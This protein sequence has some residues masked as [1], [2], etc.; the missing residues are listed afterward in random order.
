MDA[1]EAEQQ[2]CD[3]GAGGVGVAGAFRHKRMVPRL[4]LC[5][6]P[7]VLQIQ[8]D[9]V[10]KI[11]CGQV[12]AIGITPACRMQS[13]NGRKSVRLAARISKG[14]MQ[15]RASCVSHAQKAAL[16][17]TRWVLPDGSLATDLRASASWQT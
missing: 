14:T 10:G 8:F 4:Q 12:I 16:P 5:P 3:R 1:D 15:G 7:M 11:A 9:T 6:R 13:R 17:V 2:S